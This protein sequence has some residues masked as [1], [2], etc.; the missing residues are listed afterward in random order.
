MTI[1]RA[2]MIWTKV[3]VPI[4]TA[5]TVVPLINT[6]RFML[7]ADTICTTAEGIKSLQMIGESPHSIIP[8]DPNYTEWRSLANTL[9]ATAV[10]ANSQVTQNPNNGLTGF[11]RQSNQH[12][13]IRW[14][15]TV[16][17]EHDSPLMAET[18]TTVV[19]AILELYT[20]AHL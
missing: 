18:L 15:V 14:I 10:Q 13:P 8:K 11:C 5:C 2:D 1:D 20:Q 6:T 16:I 7:R 9:V 4:M 19:I 12:L 3:I 17:T